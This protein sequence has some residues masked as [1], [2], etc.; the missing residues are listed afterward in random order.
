MHIE[1]MTKKE[2]PTPKPPNINHRYPVTTGHHQVDWETLDQHKK[3]IG[4]ES[5]AVR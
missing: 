3:A 2:L 5:Q 4:D 1:M